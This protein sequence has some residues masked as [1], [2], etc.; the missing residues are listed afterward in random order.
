MHGNLIRYFDGLQGVAHM[1]GLPTAR[2]TAAGAQA[3]G[4]RF[5]QTIA[6]GRLTTVAT[7]LP[8]SSVR[9]AEVGQCVATWSSKAC[10]RVSNCRISVRISSNSITTAASPWR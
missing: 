6:G 2:F 5:P 4:A 7:V 3:L 9:R 10:T 1:A 8:M